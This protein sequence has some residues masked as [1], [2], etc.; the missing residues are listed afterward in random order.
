M[1]DSIPLGRM[2]GVKIGMNWSVLALLGL[3]VWT[4]SQNLFPDANPGLSDT[5]YLAMAL[6]AG[7]LFFVSILLHELGHAVQAKRDGMGIEGI[8]LWLF[9]GVARFTG[10]FPS[11]GAEFRIAIAGPIVSLL[12]AIGFAGAAYIPGLPSAVDGVATWLAVTNAVLL[13]FNLLPALPLDGGRIFRSAMWQWKGDFVKATR[14]AS[15]LARVFAVAIIALGLWLVFTSDGIGGAWLAIIGWFLLQA[16]GAESRA[17]VTHGRLTDLRVAD[18]MV[19]EPVTARVDMTMGEL[20]DLIGN[21]V[22][23]SGYPVVDGE[24]AV[25]MFPLSR[26]AEVPRLEW[27]TRR[28]SEVMLPRDRVAVLAAD[29]RLQP[30]IDRLQAFALNRALVVDGERLVGLLSV[31]DV[32]QALQPQP[33]PPPA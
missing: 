27:D 15:M 29:E 33:Q 25:G 3:L 17:A 2:L 21:G 23:Y 9:G 22:R 13:I 31:T 6:V 1:R 14:I 19:A 12:L 8:T 11:A 20:A 24:R 30:A 16:A 28:I 18:L 10:W 26:F 7:I 32:V 4:L 5:T